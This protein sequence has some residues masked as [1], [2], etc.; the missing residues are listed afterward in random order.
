MNERGRRKHHTDYK[1][2]LHLG[3]CPVLNFPVPG[4]PGEDQNLSDTVLILVHKTLT[5]GWWPAALNCVVELGLHRFLCQQIW[6]TAPSEA[7][8]SQAGHRVISVRN[9][10]HSTRNI[11]PQIYLQSIS[12][13]N[14]H[15]VLSFLFCYHYYLYLKF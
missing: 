5:L 7:P 12:L 10:L 14:S 11:A 2:V 8:R 4:F 15:S 6:I 3:D 1:H 13:M 9:S